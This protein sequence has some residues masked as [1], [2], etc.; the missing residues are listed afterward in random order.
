LPYVKLP[1][2]HSSRIFAVVFAAATLMSSLVACAD[3]PRVAIVDRGG[4]YHAVVK[5]EIANTVSSR[6]IGLMYR[7]HLDENAGMIFIFQEPQHLTFWMKNTEIP[8]DMIFADANG[9]I[10][11]MVQNAMPFSEQMLA[12][13]GNSLYVLEV[14]GGFA[15][16][17]AIS[18]GDTMK[19]AGFVPHAKD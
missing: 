1:T 6:E 12:V 16:R 13:N 14:N 9:K 4:A 18:A 5:V 19:F 11:G 8:L 10:V 7:S 15:K 3:E 17:H 2:I